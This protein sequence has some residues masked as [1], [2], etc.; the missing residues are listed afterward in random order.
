MGV[1]YCLEKGIKIDFAQLMFEFLSQ[2]IKD[3]KII[4]Y[5]RVLMSIFNKLKL[6]MD[7]KDLA[8][9][10]VSKA[11]NFDKKYC[12]RSESKMTADSEK[13]IEKIVEK[14]SMAGKKSGKIVKKKKSV[15]GSLAK[16]QKMEKKSVQKKVVKEKTSKKKIE[17]SDDAGKTAK[18]SGDSSSLPFVLLLLDW[19]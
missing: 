13:K 5:C 1:I 2:V 14:S 11:S 17:K 15:K 10:N 19:L 9:S 18:R 6:K 12:G 3:G 8:W 16:K 7:D 4:S